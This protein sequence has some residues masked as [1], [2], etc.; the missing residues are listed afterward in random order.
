MNSDKAKYLKWALNIAIPVGVIFAAVKYLNGEEVLN[1]LQ[2]FDYIYAVIVLLLATLYMVLQAARFTVLVRSVSELPWP[3]VMRA[4]F[5][6]Q[7]ATLLPGGVAA[8]AGLLAQIGLPVEKSA[9]PIIINSLLDQLVFIVGSMVAALFFPGARVP[10]LIVMS[11]LI[12]IGV[13]FAI[14][15]T[16][17]W[18]AGLANKVAA[19]FDQKER[20]QRFLENTE[21]MLDRK[22]L[23]PAIGLT[24]TAFVAIILMLDMSFRGIGEQIAYPTL[25]LAYVLPT[26]L[27]RIFPVPGG[28]GVTEAGMVGFL[29]SASPVGASTA[30]AAVAIFRIANV[31]W[32]A[33][34]GGIVYFLAWDG[35]EEEVP[36]AA[37]ASD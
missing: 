19:R 20:W 2:N 23:V 36:A 18:I 15:T 35:E 34:L 12:V 16:R 3:V 17:E 14:P 22:T 1:A 25:F 29:A 5:S 32:R 28:V 33:L 9:G 11:V 37:V 7:P 21:G 13:L 30:T 6:G 31:L 8:R 27:G 4:F 10:I 26:M 24:L